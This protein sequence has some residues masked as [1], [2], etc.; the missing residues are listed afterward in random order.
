M[1]C[2]QPKALNTCSRRCIGSAP[3]VSF[4]HPQIHKFFILA[5]R[6]ARSAPEDKP[7]RRKS[8]TDTGQ[9]ECSGVKL[10]AQVRQPLSPA[11]KGAQVLRLPTVSDRAH[12]ALVYTAIKRAQTRA[13]GATWHPSARDIPTGICFADTHDKN[14]GWLLLMR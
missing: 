1:I 9:G 12:C 3:H 4:T 5:S 2:F 10:Y 7:P 11:G 8:G 13:A 14:E 6:E